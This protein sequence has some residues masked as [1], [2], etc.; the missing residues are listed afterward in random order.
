MGFHC[1][2]KPSGDKKETN[3]THQVLHALAC[4]FPQGYLKSVKNFEQGLF[5]NWF[6]SI[7]FVCNLTT[8]AQADLSILFISHVNDR[9]T[10]FEPSTG[11]LLSEN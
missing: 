2:H 1:D 11:K 4:K 10:D 8:F 9:E 3:S 7:F 6:I 5:N